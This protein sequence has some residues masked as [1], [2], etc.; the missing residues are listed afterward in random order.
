RDWSSDVCS[1]DLFEFQRP[2]VLLDCRE[3]LEE[4]LALQ[5]VFELGCTHAQVVCD[6][7]LL[8]EKRPQ[9]AL[10][11]AGALE[12]MKARLAQ[13]LFQLDGAFDGVLDGAVTCVEG[14]DG[15]VLRATEDGLHLADGV[16]EHRAA[17]QTVRGERGKR[18]SY[19]V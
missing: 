7:R 12:V 10:C 16:L 5:K 13:D 1:S 2:G 19:G 18:G 11:F 9:V 3:L 17:R 15:V 6:I 4:R 14:R 8:L